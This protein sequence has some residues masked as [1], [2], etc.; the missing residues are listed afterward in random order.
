MIDKWFQISRGA[1]EEEKAG[2]DNGKISASLQRHWP[3]AD[4]TGSVEVKWSWRYAVR[5]QLF[6]LVVRLLF[7]PALLLISCCSIFPHARSPQ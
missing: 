3:R 6:Y 4:T 2:V 5:D 7:V 1:A